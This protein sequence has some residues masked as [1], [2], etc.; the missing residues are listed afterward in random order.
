M[1][2]KLPVTDGPIG[3]SDDHQ[4]HLEEA[5]VQYVSSMGYDDLV[6]LDANFREEIILSMNLNQMH[7]MVI[8]LQDT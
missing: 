7:K 6:S 8:T 2:L 1:G 4:R 5:I 3:L